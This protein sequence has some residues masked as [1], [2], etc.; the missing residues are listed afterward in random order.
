LDKTI[1]F[2]SYIKIRAAKAYS[3]A[4]YIR[5]LNRVISTAPLSAVRKAIHTIILP[6]TFFGAEV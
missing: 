3:T 1:S 2:K 4:G 6:K 5:G